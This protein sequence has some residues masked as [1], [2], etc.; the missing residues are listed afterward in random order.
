M[1]L[2]LKCPKCQANNPIYLEV[3]PHC[4][5]S[6][7]KLPARERVY[8]VEPGGPAVVK[9]T[10]PHPAPMGPASAPAAAKKTKGTRKK[11]D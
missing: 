5:K 9:P 10:P 1:G 4:G 11:K 8:V 3:C 6:L 2:W 7:K